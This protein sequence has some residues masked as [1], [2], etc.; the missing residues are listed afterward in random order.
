MT[1]FFLIQTKSIQ[2]KEPQIKLASIS[3]LQCLPISE[4]VSFISFRIIPLFMSKATKI[5]PRKKVWN[6]ET[7]LLVVLLKIINDSFTYTNF[8]QLTGLENSSNQDILWQQKNHDLQ[9]DL[10]T[11]DRKIKDLQLRLKRSTK[12]GQLKDDRMTYLEKEIED[13]RERSKKAEETYNNNLS[14]QQTQDKKS[15]SSVCL[16]LW[17]VLYLKLKDFAMNVLLVL[18]TSTFKD[19]R[20]LGFRMMGMSLRWDYTW[21]STPNRSFEV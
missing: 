14:A 12:D 17:S 5:V 4:L 7:L 18:I 20:W 9:R 16:I 6:G 19:K 11:S 21:L 3:L 2:C 1:G 8:F 13:L 15:Q 10:E